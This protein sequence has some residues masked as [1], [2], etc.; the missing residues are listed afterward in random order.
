MKGIK[1]KQ[2]G[3]NIAE[4][5][6]IRPKNPHN[7]A[8]TIIQNKNCLYQEDKGGILNIKQKSGKTSPMRLKIMRSRECSPELTTN[9]SQTKIMGNVSMKKI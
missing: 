8:H 3:H 2:N 7:Y 5:M 6:S 9:P 4:S 1:K